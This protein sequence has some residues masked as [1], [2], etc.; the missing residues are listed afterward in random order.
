[1]DDFFKAGLPALVPIGVAGLKW[2]LFLNRTDQLEYMEKLKKPGGWSLTPG[3]R[4]AIDLAV[5]APV[6]YAA[7]LIAREARG[8]DRQWALGL[9]GTGIL[10]YLAGIPAFLNT[11]DL[12]CW[13][14]VTALATAISAG[15]AAAFYKIDQNAGLMMAPLAVWM[16]LET[17]GLART[18][19]ANP[20]F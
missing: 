19:N 18:I 17:I 12:K 16:G 14:G 9:Y 6:G 1:M 11:K 5:T 7:S 8:A 10:V 15:T 2:Y 20:G 13:F 3:A 4:A